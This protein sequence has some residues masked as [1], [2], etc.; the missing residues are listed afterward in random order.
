MKLKTLIIL[1]ALSAIAVP[2]WGHHASFFD[3]EKVITVSGTVA[4]FEWKNP[5]AFLVIDTEKPDGRIERWTVEGRSPNQLLR[6]GWTQQTIR[7]GEVVTVVGR[8]PRD[9]ARLAE[10]GSHFLGAGPVRLPGGQ[11]LVFGPIDAAVR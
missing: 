11:T 2:L 4:R 7:V 1:V 6:A 8:P 9:T 3:P 5:H 10:S